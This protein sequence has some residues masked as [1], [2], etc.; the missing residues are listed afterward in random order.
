MSITLTDSNTGSETEVTESLARA[1]YGTM[2]A[3]I[4]A[5]TYH[6]NVTGMA[7][8]SLHALFQEIY[9]DHFSAQDRIAER[10]R[11]LDTHVDGR[12]ATALRA[13]PVAE[14][15]GSVAARTMVARLAEDQRTLSGCLKE[16]ACLAE[17]RGDIVSHDLAVERMEAHDKFA[18]MLEAH[19]RE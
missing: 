10:I 19:L 14:C 12:A 7:F 3:T 9:E 18:W 2:I 6:W 15:D 8:G 5:Q 1:L 16:A 17:E 11:A 13:S 4:K